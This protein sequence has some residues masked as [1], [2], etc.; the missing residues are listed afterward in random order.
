[1]LCSMLL[2]LSMVGGCEDSS[3]IAVI[4]DDLR[5]VTVSV[6]PRL[7]GERRARELAHAQARSGCPK[8]VEGVVILGESRGP[9]SWV[10]GA[11]PLTLRFRCRA[12]S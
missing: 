10:D 9:E 7:G 3:G 5:A 4:G 8:A 2:L 11:Q 12:G 1:M 6:S